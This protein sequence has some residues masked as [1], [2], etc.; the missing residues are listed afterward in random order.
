[1]GIKDRVER[2]ERQ[3]GV[4]EEI[5]PW[6]VVIY[7]DA[8]PSEAAVEAAKADYKREHPDWQGR[9]FNV[10]WVA[11]AEAKK[12]VERVIAGERTE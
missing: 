1:M 9:D 7:E 2:L 4:T 6:L 5:P 12:N 8:K 11:D 10:I 3:S